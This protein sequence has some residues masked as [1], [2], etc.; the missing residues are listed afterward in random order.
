[1]PEPFI[2]LLPQNHSE[3]ITAILIQQESRLDDRYGE[4]SREQFGDFFP[5][6]E[7]LFHRIFDRFK[8]LLSF[9]NDR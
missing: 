5:F 9:D 7:P 2:I 3:P 6:A 8:Y 4:K 1:L